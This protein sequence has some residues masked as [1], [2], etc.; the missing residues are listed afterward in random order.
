VPGAVG[1]YQPSPSAASF[2][3]ACAAFGSVPPA[4]EHVSVEC[5]EGALPP[6]EKTI[7]SAV[8]AAAAASMRRMVRG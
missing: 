6:P 1:A 8:A 2:A 4:G 5:L 3:H 7:E